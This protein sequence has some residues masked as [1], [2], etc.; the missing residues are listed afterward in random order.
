MA[1][2]AD[3]LL[4]DGTSALSASE[5]NAAGVDV[6]VSLVPRV[7]EVYV[8][9]VSGTSPTLTV[10]IQESD[11]NSTWQDYAS[12]PQITAA[13]RYYLTVQSNARYLR[14]HAT[15]GGTS[16]NF[17]NTVIGIVPAGRYTSW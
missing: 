7:V 3:L 11:D 17:G 1:F 2:D 10:K 16:P 6:G 8:P 14:Y 12:F 13:G 5:T 4:R 15:V 9:S